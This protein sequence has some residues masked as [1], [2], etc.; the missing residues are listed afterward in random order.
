MSTAEPTRSTAARAF[1][2]ISVTVASLTGGCGP[3]SS[4]SCERTRPT[5]ATNATIAQRER[6]RD[7]Y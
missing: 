2:V 5:A 7:S 1:S 4:S 6:V 3:E